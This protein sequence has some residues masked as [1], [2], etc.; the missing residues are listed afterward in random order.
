LVTD[1]SRI[2]NLFQGPQ[3]T[4]A[5]QQLY[6]VFLSRLHF[7]DANH[8]VLTACREIRR[9]ANSAGRKPAAAFT[10]FWELE[11]HGARK[12]FDSMWRSLR[13]MERV[14]LGMRLNLVS[15]KWKHSEHHQLIYR[16][17]P[18]L[19]LKGRYRLG[20]K[21]MEIAL[22]MASHQKGWAYEWFPHVY[23]PIKKPATIYEVALSHFYSVLNRNLSEWRL[24]D[25]FLDDLDPK[26]FRMSGQTKESIRTNSRKLRPFCKWMIAERRRRL[27]TRT[28][29][30]MRDLV[31]PPSK[32]QRRQT[33]RKRL[34]LKFDVA[35]GKD[36]LEQKLQQLFPELMNLPEQSSFKA[37]L[38]QQKN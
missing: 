23:K 15:H 11:A 9:Y 22:E 5:A 29:D 34:L 32:V 27:F 13:A 12:D 24:W 17:V 35:P 1:L 3:K 37:V 7:A 16:Y 30:G 33:A 4:K 19:Y 28:T 8:R 26:L 38:N 21:L 14:A 6:D 31:E 36:L 10:Y 20:R 2:P 18:L 25:K